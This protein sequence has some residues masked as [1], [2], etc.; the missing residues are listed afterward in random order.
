MQ[1]GEYMFMPHNDALPNPVGGERR[2]Y[3]WR[4]GDVAYSLHGTGAPIVF[5]HSIHAAA[6]NAEWRHNIPVLAEQGA[7]CY[8]PDFPGFGASDRAPIHYTAELYLDFIRDFLRDVVGE[9]AVLVGSSLGGT[10]AIAV[11]AAHPELVSAVCAIGPAGVS[12]LT[13]PGGGAGAAVQGLFRTPVVGSTLFGALVSRWSIRF[14][15]KGIYAFGL[16]RETERLFWL[17]ANRPNARFAPAAFVGMKL[18]HDIRQKIGALSCPLLIAWGTEATQT[19]YRESAQVMEHA[20][21]A[22]FQP[23][24]AGDMPH[25]ERPEAFNVAL[26]EFIASLPVNAP[27]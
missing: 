3:R 14:F 4:D 23:I 9:P 6:W 27:A 13:T 16:D 26:R 22:A 10:Y 15:L 1:P 11:A 17:A 20:P 12:R 8:A 18:N 19:P 2:H 7:C 21:N 25:D 5:L 24:H